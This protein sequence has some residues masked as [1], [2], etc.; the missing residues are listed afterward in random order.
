MQFKQVLENKAIN[1][2]V[3]KKSGHAGPFPNL[4]CRT[5]RMLWGMGPRQAFGKHP[6]TQLSNSVVLKDYP[7]KFLD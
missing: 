6:R 1:I 3:E 4:V 5:M 2:M 7:V